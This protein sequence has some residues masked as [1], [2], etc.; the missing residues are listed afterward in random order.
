MTKK[1]APSVTESED[2][3][4]PVSIGLGLGHID[5]SIKESVHLAHLHQHPG[6][7]V[8]MDVLR[9]VSEG[10]TIALRDRTKSIEDIRFDQGQC[11]AVLCV[12]DL[13]QKEMP[14]WYKEG[15][16]KQGSGTPHASQEHS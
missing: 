3:L 6:W 7:S 12:A 5:L 4:K 13:V 15:A 1:P 14:A 2:K 9:A 16:A 10:A 11:E 8:L